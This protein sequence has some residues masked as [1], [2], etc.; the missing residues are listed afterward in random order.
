MPEQRK[1]Y[2]FCEDRCLFEA[3]TKEQTIAAIAEATGVVPESIDIDAAFITKIKEQNGNE[4]VKI[5]IGTEAQF[6]ALETKADDTLYIYTTDFEED[7]TTEVEKIKD[8]RTAVP[9]AEHAE[10]ATNATKTSFTNK[11][12]KVAFP[13]TTI[14][15]AHKDYQFRGAHNSF[16]LVHFDGS[17]VCYSQIS[18]GDGE[19]PR[20]YRLKIN[21]DGTITVQYTKFS[22]EMV[23]IDEDPDFTLFYREIE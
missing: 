20:Y 9:Q 4:A 22:E 8:G 19:D 5:W 16:G 7:I 3:L 12:W 6:N 14:L 17:D 11:G 2:V 21:Q 23:W 18:S 1:Y 13:T 10:T 15:Q